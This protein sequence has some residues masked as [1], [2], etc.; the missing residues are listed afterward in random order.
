M[1][2][3]KIN[4]LNPRNI[5]ARICYNKQVQRIRYK[6]GLIEEINLKTGKTKLKY[7]KKK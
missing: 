7:K 5:W 4:Y 1:E 2:I 6:D 3:K